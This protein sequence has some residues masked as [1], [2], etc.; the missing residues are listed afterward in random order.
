VRELVRIIRR[1]L[2]IDWTNNEIIKARIRDNVRLLLLR[3]NFKPEETEELTNVIY[4]QAFVLF[5]DYAF[6]HKS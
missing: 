2:T 6:A 3:N 5:K 4:E 1:D